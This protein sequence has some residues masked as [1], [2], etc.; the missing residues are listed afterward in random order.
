MSVVSY[1]RRFTRMRAQL[2]VRCRAPPISED[3]KFI[4]GQEER[5]RTREEAKR[6]E[7]VDATTCSDEK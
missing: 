2:S 3:I 7:E 6:D 4:V 5:K 1:L